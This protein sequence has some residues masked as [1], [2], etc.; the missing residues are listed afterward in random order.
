MQNVKSLKEIYTEYCFALIA[1]LFSGWIAI[2]PYSGYLILLLTVLIILLNFSTLKVFLHVC[3]TGLITAYFLMPREYGPPNSA[4]LLSLYSFAALIFL[5][6]GQLNHIFSKY[7]KILVFLCFASIAQRILMFFLDLPYFFVDLN[8]QFFNVYW[9]FYLERTN[10]SIG[11]VDQIIGT[12]RFHGP[13]FEPG[14]LGYALGIS[15]FG[16]NSKKILVSIF[17]FGILSLS[18]AFIVISF[19]YV[20]EKLII[21]GNYYPVILAI[22]F[23]FILY[24]SLDKD[25]FFY[26]S[27]FGRFLGE[28]D[29]VLN[30]RT[31][32][33]EQEQIELFKKIIFENPLELLFGIGF[34]LPGSGGSY[35]V[36]LLSTGIIFQLIYFPFF[37]YLI[38]KLC[39]MR[40]KQMF[41]RLLVVSLIFYILGNWLSIIFIFLFC[42]FNQNAKPTIS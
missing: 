42:K 16:S 29:K 21:R 27:T 28:S 37:L 24:F 19:I 14:A 38:K 34:D 35:R 36:W 15:L 40:V 39:N 30:T 13:F 17:F 11:D 20:V 2:Y 5:K 18:A 31:S 9:P 33:F 41:F 26:N 32:V 6:D 23:I 25:S 12:Y 10:I 22:L 8:P 3:I 4:W 1:I 7:V